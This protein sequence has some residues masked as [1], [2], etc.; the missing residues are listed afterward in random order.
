M[1]WRHE[2]DTAVVASDS[3]FVR[4]TVRADLLCATVPDAA[5]AVAAGVRTRQCVPD[6]FKFGASCCPYRMQHGK[7]ANG[8]SS[9]CKPMSP[10]KCSKVRPGCQADGQKVCLE[11]A[12]GYWLVPNKAAPMPCHF[13]TSCFTQPAC[14]G[15]PCNDGDAST[16]GTV[17]DGHS[18]SCGPPKLVAT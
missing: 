14:A 17:C 10:K 2:T 11:A 6:D 1:A 15:T 7:D 4:P 8:S 18:R 5:A 13:G 3:P 9:S 16:T 12:P